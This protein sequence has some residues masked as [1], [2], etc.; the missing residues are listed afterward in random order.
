MVFRFSWYPNKVYPDVKF[1]EFPQISETVHLY[2]EEKK[3]YGALQG[4]EHEDDFVE[5]LVAS[6]RLNDALVFGVRH[7]QYVHN[8]VIFG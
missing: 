3:K 1:H 2:I 4:T 6:E 5:W 8:D 7:K